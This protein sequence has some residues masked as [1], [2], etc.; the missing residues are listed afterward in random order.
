[1]LQLKE[2]PTYAHENGIVVKGDL[3]IGIY[4]Y[5]CDAWVNPA[6]YNMDAQARTRRPMISL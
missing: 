3:P 5:S 1:M 4:R 6:L 2:S